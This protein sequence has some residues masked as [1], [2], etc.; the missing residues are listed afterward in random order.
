MKKTEITKKAI[1][2]GASSG[3]G[4]QL[5]RIMANDGYEVGITARR[6]ELLEQ[7]KSELPTKTCIKQMDISETEKAMA[8]LDELIKEMGGVDVIIVSAGIGHIN[9]DLEWQPEQDTID[10]NVSGATA[11]INIAMNHFIEKKSGHLVGISSISALR[12]AGE[13]PAYNASKAYLSN[14]L[15]GMRLKAKKLKYKI[16][17]TDIKPGLVDTAMAQ[18]DGLFWVMPVETASKQIYKAIKKKKKDVVVTKRWKIIAFIMKR[19]PK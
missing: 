14:Y 15:Q 4:K 7:L 17:V 11:I 6:L 18:G 10:T 19:L 12:G 2:V 8:G 3:I 9:D 1:I 5:A 13:C 16:A